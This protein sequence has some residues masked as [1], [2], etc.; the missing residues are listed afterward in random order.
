MLAAGFE[1]LAK[2]F[3]KRILDEWEKTKMEEA[4]NSTLKNKRTNGQ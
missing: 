3:A 2:G 4:R 1:N